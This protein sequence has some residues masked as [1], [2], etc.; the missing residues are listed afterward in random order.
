MITDLCEH[1][2]LVWFEK[3]QGAD[4]EKHNIINYSKYERV[5]AICLIR[6]LIINT[7]QMLPNIFNRTPTT[8]H[9]IL[10]L[11]DQPVTK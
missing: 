10:E 3:V 1:W 8:K 4:E 2:E 7:K 6:A 5:D 9:N 11:E